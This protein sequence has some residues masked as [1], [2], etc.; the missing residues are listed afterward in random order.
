VIEVNA[1]EPMFVKGKKDKL[2]VYEVLG[3]K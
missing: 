1:W 3:A 2:L